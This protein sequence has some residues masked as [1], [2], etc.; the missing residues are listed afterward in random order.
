MVKV[1]LIQPDINNLDT[2]HFTQLEK[3]SKEEGSFF[4]EDK[5]KTNLDSIKKIIRDDWDY[6][7]VIDGEV[8]SGKS[9]F[10]QQL[11][12]YLSDGKFNID[13]IT[14]KPK[15]FKTQVL[16]SKHYTTNIMDEA[17]R[18][19][20]ARASLS[21]TNKMLV[22][23]LNEI[24]QLNLFT[25]V[26]LPSAW[27]LDKYALL[28]RCKGLFHV[29]VNND[30]QRGFWKFYSNKEDETGNS[31]FKFFFSD[32]KNRYRYPKWFDLNGRFP[33]YYPLG[34]ELY[35]EK[36]AKSLGDYE[37]PTEKDNRFIRTEKR[38]ALILKDVLEA[39]RKEKGWTQGEICDKFGLNKGT[40]THFK[41]EF[42]PTGIIKC[43]NNDE[44]S[45]K[46]KEFTN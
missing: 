24:R 9:V 1:K 4:L 16:K 39:Y 7:Y 36:K 10:A 14:F 22:S 30:R 6:L 38:Y 18:G 33:K 19:L 23:L 44:I 25:F 42:S 17:F 46:D 43:E 32:P 15:E 13:N 27:D 11:A 31:R 37:A 8:G 5:L 12:Y 2:W 45:E 21:Q 41:G 29:H 35:E 20:S 40:Y 34:K 26:L 3:G 28:H